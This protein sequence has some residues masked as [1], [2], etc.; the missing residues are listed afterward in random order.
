MHPLRA[1]ALDALKEIDVRADLEDRARLDM[2]G[3]LRVGDLV[4]IGTEPGR[5]LWVVDAEEEVRVASPGSVEERGLVDHVGTA[6]DR[7]FG[8][9]R[10]GAQL[11]RAVLDGPVELDDHRGPA[12]GPKVREEPAFVFEPALPD[13]VEL[14]I[15]AHRAVNEAGHRRPFELRQVLAGEVGDEVRG[16]VHRAAVDRLHGSTIPAGRVT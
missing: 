2:A 1:H 14:G 10:R 16:R 7:P 3:Q 12:L 13:D 8:L 11:L 9:G 15:V 6:G 4:V 5:A